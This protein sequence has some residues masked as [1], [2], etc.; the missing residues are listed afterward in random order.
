VDR[1]ENGAWTLYQ[2][3]FPVPEAVF[4]P[5]MKYTSFD[6][7]GVMFGGRRRQQSR[8]FNRIDWLRIGRP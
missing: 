4:T 2:G 5:D 7:I 3:G 8:N 1:D 6:R